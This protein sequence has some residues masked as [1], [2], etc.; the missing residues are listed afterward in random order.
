MAVSVEDL[1]EMRTSLESSIDTKM[2]KM[3]AQLDTLTAL[4]NNIM[5][6]DKPT[7]EVS[8]DAD[9]SSEAAQRAAAGDRPVEEDPEKRNMVP[10]PH[11]KMEMENTVVYLHLNLPIHL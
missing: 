4:I 2:S 7:I 3:E 8:D 6:K 11:L 10:L 5:N 9:L 1:N